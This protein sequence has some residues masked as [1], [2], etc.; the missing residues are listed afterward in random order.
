[1]GEVATCYDRPKDT[2]VGGSEQEGV[3]QTRAGN[4][5]TRTQLSTVTDSGNVKRA[6][7]GNN[8][9]SDTSR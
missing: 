4:T 3:R 5:C 9:L 8:V 7:K 6:G 1:M 2:R